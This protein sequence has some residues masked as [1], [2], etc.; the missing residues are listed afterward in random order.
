MIILTGTIA[1]DYIMDFPSIFGDHIL[2]DQ[3]HNINLSFIVNKFERRR[4]GT[5]GNVSYTMGLLAAPHILFSFAGKDFTE[6]AKALKKLKISLDNVSVDKE[7]YT[8][9]GFAMTDKINNQIWG[10]FYGAAEKNPDLQ[11]K[12]VATNKD[13]VLIGPAGAKGSMAM[14]RQAVTLGIPYMF[15]PGFILT[16]VSNE[17]LTLG[18]NHATYLIGNDYEMNLMKDRVKNWGKLFSSKIIITT[19]GEK[20]ALI[21]T[22]NQK[23]TIVAVKPHAVIDPSGAGDAWRGGFLAGLHRGFDLQTCGQMGAVAASYA[24]EKYG[25]QEHTYSKKDFEKRYRQNF[26]SLLEL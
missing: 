26:G 8:A 11:L 20:G 5:A 9:T 4:G 25:C 18:V 17:E 19:L 3:I 21:A 7:T 13:L 10:Y 1:Y 23:F 2:P 24:I 15:D 16:Q 14:I 6:Y 22:K 12:N